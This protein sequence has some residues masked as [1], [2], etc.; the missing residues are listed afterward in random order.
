MSNSVNFTGAD[1][2]V[3]G[4]T[5][6]GPATVRLRFTQD[7]LAIDSSASNDS[8]NP[9]NYSVVGP[10]Q[11][12][13]TTVTQVNEDP[14]SVDLTLSEMLVAGSWTVTVSNVVSS[15]SRPLQAPFGAS[16]SVEGT[17]N[18][19]PVS[20][21][22]ESD[23][24][25]DVIRK[26]LPLSFRGKAW[27]AL[28][29]AI[30]I[31]DKLN[32]ENAQK[33]FA[34]LFTSS[35]SGKYL[36]KKAGDS[37]VGRPQGLGMKDELF[38]SLAIK[39][40]ARKLVHESVLDILEV[41]YGSDSV[42]A[43]VET[44]ITEPFQIQDGDELDVLLDER[45]N[46][47]VILNS[48]DFSRPSQ[49]SALEVATALT[50]TFRLNKSKATAVAFKDAASG[51]NKVR[52]Y[53]GA[54]GLAS[55]VRILRGRGRLSLRFP[56]K[57]TTIAMGAT[58]SS[59]NWNISI[60]TS[61]LA[62]WK[63][64]GSTPVD[65]SLV[66]EGD[67]LCAFGSSI[68]PSNKGSFFVKSVV[69]E[70][71]GSILEQY[72]IVENGDATAQ[73]FTQLTLDDV[74]FF[75]PKKF[76]AQG[77]GERDVVVS[78]NAPGVL[79][80][81]I[82][83]T[84]Q[85]V[86]RGE[87]VGSY[88]PE[89]EA[90]DLTSVV[91]NG[92]TITVNTSGH[93][94]AVGDKIQ[95]DGS[96]SPMTFPSINAGGENYTSSSLAT[97]WYLKANTYNPSSGI[98]TSRSAGVKVGDNKALFIG[99]FGIDAESVTPEN[100]DLDG[101][102]YPV[103]SW[104]NGIV[105]SVQKVEVTGTTTM[106]DGSLRYN[107]NKSALA[108]M[109]EARIFHAA[110][111]YA[112]G[113]YVFV[114]GGGSPQILIDKLN[115]FS[116]TEIYNVNSNTWI[117]GPSL[118]TE[119]QRH[120][121]HLL[122]NGNILIIGGATNYSTAL[123]AC[124]IFN[125]VSGT[126][127]ATSPMSTPRVGHQ[128]VVLKDGRVLVIGGLSLGRSLD[129]G[130]GTLA[131]WKF[132]GDLNDSS[133]NGFN[134][135]GVG[136]PTSY[137]TS[138]KVGQSLPLSDFRYHVS[139]ASAPTI[140]STATALQGEWTVQFWV[141][142]NGQ[143]PV[144]S[145]GGSG[146]SQSNNIQLEIGLNGSFPV[147]M[148]CKWQNGSGN[149][150]N[151]SY[152]STSTNPF[153]SNVA[154]GWAHVAVVKKKNASISNTYDVTFYINGVSKQTFLAQPNCDGG[155]SSQWYIG[156][157]SKSAS[158]NWLSASSL[159]ELMV[160]SFAKG[161]A[162]LLNDIRRG[163]GHL[164]TSSEYAS[165][166]PNLGVLGEHLSSCEIYDPASG[167]WSKVGSMSFARARHAA[168]LLPD[169]RVLVSGGTG[170]QATVSASLVEAIPGVSQADFGPNS[171]FDI[172]PLETAEIYDPVSNT[173]SNA[174]Q[175]SKPRYGHLSNAIMSKNQVMVSFG[176]NESASA[177]E[178]YIPQKNRW[179]RA[180][181]TPSP[182][183]SFRETLYSEAGGYSVD[184]PKNFNLDEYFGNPSSVVMGDDLVYWQFY[185]GELA[186]WPQNVNE[187]WVLY[188]GVS[189]FYVPAQDSIAYQNTNG[190]YSVDTVNGNSFTYK[191]GSAATSTLE[192][193][194]ITPV[195]APEATWGAHLVSPR[196]GGSLTSVESTLTAPIFKGQ[197]YS[198]L[199][200]ANALEF[201]D[202]EGWVWIGYGEQDGFG[203]VKYLGRTGSTSLTF[204]F[205]YKIPASNKVG[206]KVTLLSGNTPF[207]PDSIQAN[208]AFLT[209]SS[210]GRVAAMNQ[211]EASLAA[212]IEANFT[213]KY[214][215]DKGLGNQGYS[216]VGNKISDKVRV[217]AGDDIDAEVTEAGEE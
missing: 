18:L 29:A 62:K 95:V 93:S 166:F 161:E 106:P 191:V 206:T 103:V 151:M 96:R 158:T 124:S 7:P 129:T 94:L 164:N 66:V 61:G 42:R 116:S 31:G 71:A 39:T 123:S 213:I 37:G 27:D 54:L 203:P 11:V 137:K 109:G 165:D 133:S 211:I 117:S 47:K 141:Y 98:S 199:S 82:P 40:T 174:G 45:E 198:T 128:S 70:F 190:V 85:V 92:N 189:L 195:A 59:I 67:I 196:S 75:R 5:V 33:A 41:F 16:T 57:I 184:G 79:D 87:G 64:S 187:P 91:G 56:E 138:G 172:Q 188:D 178:I 125:T 35:A 83:A 107:F 136:G 130:S 121:Q 132:D 14:Q 89:S 157:S 26:H 10:G 214:P 55:S 175:M 142:G 46:I 32:W 119:T 21:G 1:F 147:G 111:A 176:E 105:K 108:S 15:T 20:E 77:F 212:G 84:T 19:P 58:P 65:L 155:T 182:Q 131:Y 115:S 193:V 9:N 177:S 73:N 12:I 49:A 48:S 217:W 216:I 140:A 143:G 159:D 110:T 6:R 207:V 204:D 162:E 25:E 208:S 180:R 167:N 145:F 183:I 168:S 150:V 209:S 160:S 30:S 28:I 171:G 74:V 97:H 146:T 194:T 120:T 152:T 134:L 205:N 197:K 81:V 104:Q 38:R 169:G 51:K 135:T 69:T 17:Y 44:D 118:L 156:Q 127:S 8:L 2:S 144:V 99:G 185:H 149:Y 90:L 126:I 88:I 80:V 112:D 53:S 201:P 181:K 34:Q 60:P 86:Q 170:Y 50:R 192:S 215:G 72:V 139:A 202:K 36:D 114:S 63:V 210:V 148:T 23:G 122:T 43:F 76:A 186:G 113:A 200:V 22:A 154:G 163:I 173:W 101:V 13:V 102:V 78:Q 24:P 52:I 100:F 3:Q 179:I 4:L 153:Y 68:A